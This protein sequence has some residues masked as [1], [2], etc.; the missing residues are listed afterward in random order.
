MVVMVK[1]SSQGFRNENAYCL[2]ISTH[3]REIEVLSD[4]VPKVVKN[5]WSEKPESFSR[6][7]P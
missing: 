1:A 7:Q 3:G 2:D 5:I 6:P 4:D